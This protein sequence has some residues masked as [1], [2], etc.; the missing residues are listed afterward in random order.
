M[1]KRLQDLSDKFVKEST[2]FFDYLSLLP[3]EDRPII[4]KVNEWCQVHL[5]TN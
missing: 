1:A 4:E 5:T 2:T 3:K